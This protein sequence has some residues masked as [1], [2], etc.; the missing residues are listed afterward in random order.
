[1]K[2]KVGLITLSLPKN[3]SPL[4]PKTV[5]IINNISK[6]AK[7]IMENNYLDVEK[8]EEAVENREK[9]LKSI[10]FLINKDIDCIIF[11]IGAWP[12]PS[13][14]IDAIDRLNKRIPIII[15]GYDDLDALSLSPASQFHGAFDDMGVEHEF[16]YANPTDE[17]FIRKI[18]I[19]AGAGYA[20]NKLNGMNLGLF[21]G[22]Y[23]NMYTGTAD[24]LMVKK[25]FGV[26][27]IH[28]NEFCLV[29][30]AKKIE[31]EKVE[32]FSEYMHKN[33][34]NITAPPD[35]INRSI[36][37]YFAMNN[38]K[39]KYNLDFASVKCMTEVMGEY[40]SHCLS[41]SKH[42]DEGFIISCEGDIN[43]AI[44]MQLLYLLSNSAVGFGDFYELTKDNVLRIANCGAFA[45]GFASSYKEVDFP[46]QYQLV[47][48]GCTGMTTSYIC[49]P[50]EVTIARLGRIKGEYVMQISSGNAIKKSKKE[51]TGLV[52]L[53]HIFIQLK[54]DRDAFVQNIRSNHLHFIYG[55]YEEELKYICKILKIKEIV[56]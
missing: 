43:A 27:I 32:A 39:D 23:M 18:K 21:G 56:C 28:I 8:I 37:L 41:V 5:N 6:K 3:I 1:M 22:R 34:G 51:L 15:W 30:E 55:H 7:E 50:G 40:C 2:P 44:T 16:L 35:I 48:G 47:P 11:Q 4:N 9:A 53:P 10:D 13:I 12:S 52:K 45:T 14:A 26:E 17:E 42:I 29:N 25:I 49:K 36:R 20:V 31:E 54:R 19:I 24:P 33:Y 38:L 46:E